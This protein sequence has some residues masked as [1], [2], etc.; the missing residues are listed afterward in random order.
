MRQ[1]DCILLDVVHSIYKSKTVYQKMEGGDLY[2]EKKEILLK[3]I[4]VKKWFR[5]ECISSVEQYVTSKNKIAKNRSVIF[6]KF[7]GRFYATYHSPEDIIRNI[8]A[9]PITQPIGFAY[10][11]NIHPSKSQ[12]QQHRTRRN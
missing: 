9:T 3:Q 11:L 12:V 2:P 8:S 10:D 5:K 6:D 7:S 4:K 1:D